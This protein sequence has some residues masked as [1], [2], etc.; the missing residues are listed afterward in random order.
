MRLLSYPVQLPTSWKEFLSYVRTGVRHLYLC[1]VY[2][3]TTSICLLIRHSRSLSVRLPSA[4]ASAAATT[5]TA[6]CVCVCVC[7][8]EKTIMPVV[9]SPW[10]IVSLF[11]HIT[12]LYTIFYISNNATICTIYTIDQYAASNG[13]IYSADSTSTIVRHVC[14]VTSGTRPY[15]KSSVP[16]DTP[17]PR[18][19]SLDVHSQSRHVRRGRRC[20]LCVLGDD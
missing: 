8:R 10:T 19:R 2:P 17:Q 4:C 9:A 3:L 20:H 14:T 16:R 18:H 12:Y 13:S 15:E 1:Y 7:E 11:H 6:V 5:T